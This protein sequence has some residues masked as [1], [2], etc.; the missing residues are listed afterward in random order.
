MDSLQELP[1]ASE[2]EVEIRACTIQAVERIK[3]TLKERHGMEDCPLPHSI[4]L[5]WFLWEQ[6]ERQR[7]TSPPHHRTVTSFY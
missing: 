7:M 2:E 4:Q 3:A 6:G 5:D 1:A